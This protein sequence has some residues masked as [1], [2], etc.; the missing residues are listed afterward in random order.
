MKLINSKLHLAIALLIGI[1]FTSSVQ[2]LQCDVKAR[3][4]CIITDERP[5]FYE[6]KNLDCRKFTGVYD[7]DIEKVENR[8]YSGVINENGYPQINV[9]YKWQ[10]CNLNSNPN[11]D[12]QIS[13]QTSYAKLEQ[14]EQLINKSGHISQGNCRTHKISTFM[15]TEVRY[16]KLSTYMEG[17]LKIG[18]KIYDTEPNDKVVCQDYNF[19]RTRIRRSDDCKLEAQAKCYLMDVNTGKS[20]TTMCNGN[21]EYSSNSKCSVPVRYEWEACNYEDYDITLN[22]R[23]SKLKLN[24][25]VVEKLDTTIEAT[26]CVT[27]ISDKEID[28]SKNTDANSISLSLR[29]KGKGLRECRDYTYSQV[30]ISDAFPSQS[31]SISSAPT[32]SFHPTEPPTSHP[33]EMPSTSEPTEMP[34]TDMPTRQ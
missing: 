21:I 13:S 16:H 25:S 32:V 17:F 11:E 27:F 31:P 22:P 3:A 12:V 30:S 26:K 7:I 6:F 8:T 5:E 15:D 23:R 24:G 29:G 1:V 28:C 10:M 34:T 20:T 9:Q 2:A 18:D 33:T 14:E 19:Y 4:S